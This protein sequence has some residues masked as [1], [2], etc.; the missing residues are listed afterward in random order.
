MIELI[1]HIGPIKGE[2]FMTKIAYQITLPDNC[3]P[4]NQNVVYQII[5]LFCSFNLH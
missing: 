1:L 5:D 2:Y 4:H 3:N